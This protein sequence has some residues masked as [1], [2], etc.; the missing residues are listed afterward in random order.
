[1]MVLF[2]PTPIAMHLP[3]RAGDEGGKTR[4]GQAWACDLYLWNSCYSAAFRN[5][6][7]RIAI[8]ADWIV[9]LNTFLDNPPPPPFFLFF[10]FQSH[11]PA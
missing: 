9:F 10:K 4:R 3:I 2:C 6:V 1:M 7:L 5:Y 8:V 11:I